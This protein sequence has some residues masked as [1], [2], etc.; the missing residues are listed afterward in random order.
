MNDVT[1][2]LRNALIINDDVVITKNENVNLLI[3]VVGKGTIRLNLIGYEQPTYGISFE[4][5]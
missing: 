2:Q 5:L 3:R 4:L 1:N